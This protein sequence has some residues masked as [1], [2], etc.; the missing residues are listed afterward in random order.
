LAVLVMTSCLAALVLTLL[1]ADQTLIRAMQK[2]KPTVRFEEQEGSLYIDEKIQ[3]TRIYLQTS[4]F[5]LRLYV[6][7]LSFTATVLIFF[8]N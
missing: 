2:L 4:S 3:A 6:V 8:S 7:L 1:M 5:F